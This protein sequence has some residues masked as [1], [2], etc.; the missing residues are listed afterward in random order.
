LPSWSPNGYRIAYL[1]GR[2]LRIVGGNGTGDH[3]F[4]TGVG[5]VAPVWRPGAG[6]VLAFVKRGRLT[7][8]NDLGTKIWSRSG[9][10][11]IQLAW[12]PNGRLLLVVER[13]GLRLLDSRGRTRKALAL[14]AGTVAGHAAFSPDGRSIAL[15]RERAGLSDVRLLSVPGR[16]WH[17]RAGAPVSGAFS[18]M[19]WS[20]DGRW[21]LLAWRDANQ[22][23]FVRNGRVKGVGNVAQA[24]ASGAAQAAFP[25]LGGWCCY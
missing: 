19:E 16:S 21:L 14:P 17:E 25:S 6:Y 20:P 9:I 11:P 4:A 3:L 12:S 5:A 18:A 23:L 24:F 13:G 2:D 7:V 22:W 1:S 15:L 10:D 8:A